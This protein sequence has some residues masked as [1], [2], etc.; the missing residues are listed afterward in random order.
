MDTFR[1]REIA[2]NIDLLY[3]GFYLWVGKFTIRLGGCQLID[4]PYK[5]PGHL[6]RYCGLAIIIK[7]FSLEI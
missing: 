4:K 1:R 7:G 2:Y 5:Y 3:S 6:D